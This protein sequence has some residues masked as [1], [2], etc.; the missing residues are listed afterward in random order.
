MKILKLADGSGGSLE[1][2]YREQSS[3]VY[4]A[5]AQIFIQGEYDNGNKGMHFDIDEVDDISELIK[6]LCVIRG[7][8]VE[9]YKNKPTQP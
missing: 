5:E 7:K 8:M 3:Q 9:H 2:Q 6:W 4:L 1:L